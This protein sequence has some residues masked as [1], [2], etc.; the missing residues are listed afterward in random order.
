MSRLLLLASLVGLLAIALPAQGAQPCDPTTSPA[1]ATLGSGSAGTFTVYMTPDGWVYRESNGMPG[2]QRSDDV[3]D[4]T[5]G[6][7][8]ASDSLVY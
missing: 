1:W 2:L 4:D 5:C 7:A 3:R 6:G 8:Y